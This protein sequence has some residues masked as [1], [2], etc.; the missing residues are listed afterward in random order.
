MILLLQSLSSLKQ[1]YTMH[2]DIH[3]RYR[4]EV[5]GEVVARFNE[6]FLLSLSN[7]SRCLVVDDSLTVLPISASTLSVDPVAKNQKFAGD[8]ELEELKDKLKDT[9]PVSCLLSLCKTLDQV[10]NDFFLNLGN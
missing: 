5:H 10:S 1:L 6:R 2:M 7:H 3:E 8:D 4:T 9:Q